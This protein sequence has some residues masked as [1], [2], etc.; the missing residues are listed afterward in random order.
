MKM[1][2]EQ[3]K[4]MVKELLVE[5]LQEGL[6]GVK[7]VVSSPRALGITECPRGP[8]KGYRASNQ[9]TG[10]KPAFDPRLD[11]PVN[12]GRTQPPVLKEAIRMG[13]AGNPMM[14]DI[15][16]DTAATTLAE[17]TAHGDKGDATLPHQVARSGVEQFQGDSED[18]FG[19][20]AAQRE[21]GGSHWADLAFAAP[22]GLPR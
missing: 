13:A 17:Q 5:V 16:A 14:A 19:E 7:G 20:A 1:T 11:T 4:A 10:V 3:L 9:S 12:R 6:G 2:R 18:V 22:S 21:D 15:L 8:G